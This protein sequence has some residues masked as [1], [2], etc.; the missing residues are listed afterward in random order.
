MAAVTSVVT[1]STHNNAPVTAR[2]SSI[3]AP[4]MLTHSPKPDHERVRI[5]HSDDDDDNHGDDHNGHNDDTENGD[6]KPDRRSILWRRVAWATAALV[7]LVLIG[8][9]AGPRSSSTPSSVPTNNNLAVLE[10]ANNITV[11]DANDADP[12]PLAIPSPAVPPTPS[13]TVVAWDPYAA[14]GREPGNLEPLASKAAPRVPPLKL[15]PGILAVPVAALSVTTLAPVLDVFRAAGFAVYLFHWDGAAGVAA[16]SAAW[17][18]YA[19]VTST[20]VLRQ[21][22][23]WYAKRFLTPAV[24][25]AYES[26]WLW[27]DDVALDSLHVTE[28]QW[29]PLIFVEIMRKYALAIAQPALS[30]GVRP[31]K[32]GDVVRWQPPAPGDGTIGRLTNFAEVMFPVFSAAAW[33]D[34]VWESIPWDGHAYWGLDLVWYPHCATAGH[35]RMAVVDAMPV[36][37]LDTKS[38][39]Q[40]TAEHI[41]E[42]NAFLDSFKA[43]CAQWKASP[44]ATASDAVATRLDHECAYLD[45]V[46]ADFFASLRTLDTL[47][48]TWAADL[49]QCPQ[50]EAWAGIPNR[51]W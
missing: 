49:Q 26:V 39:S 5:H 51:P 40:S 2:R 24:V 6:K 36:Q 10:D 1:T 33:R 18:A 44:N 25:Q 7:A 3:H 29:D 27:D 31:Y 38:F 13:P 50:S 46:Q 21:S 9:V 19:N 48:A 23:F 37:H 11:L 47:D 30:A 22:K 8:L 28:G 16:W 35:C 34:C 17:P 20:I 42:M 15:K 14:I 41:V 32:Q 4:L 12:K 45:H 43:V